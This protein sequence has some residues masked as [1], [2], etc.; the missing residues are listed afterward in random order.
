VVAAATALVLALSGAAVYR[1]VDCRSPVCAPLVLPPGGLHITT[2]DAGGVYADYGGAYGDVVRDDIPNLN[3]HV[4]SSTGSIENISRLIAGTAQL[5]FISADTLFSVH[6]QEQRAN[7]VGRIRAVARIYD[8]YVQIA[9]RA[10]GP[11]HTIA[12]LRGRRVSVGKDGSSVEITAERLLGVAGLDGR[13]AVT[14]RSVGVTDSALL[15]RAGK[16]DA[17]FWVGGLGTGAV[18]YLAQEVKL[19]LLPV[20]TYT[21][22][23]QARYGTVYRTAAVPANTYPGVPDVSTVSVPN[24]L[25][26]TTALS[27]DLV[28]RLTRSLFAHRTRVA[29]TVPSGRVLDIR[30]AISTSSIPLHPGAERYYRSVKP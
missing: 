28:E 29:A 13:T 10:D 25:V 23:L 27:A 20:D 11:I 1:A 24:Y 6:S 16:I 9:V 22:A 14:R 4:D 5:G 18:N 15:L 26:T 12:D 19:R 8:E 3:V 2:S 17:F 30:S 21:D 7:A